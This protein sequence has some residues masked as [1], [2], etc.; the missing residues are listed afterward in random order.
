MNIT[1]IT[2]LALLIPTMLLARGEPFRTDINP[3]LLYYRAFELAPQSM[4]ESNLDYLYSKEGSSEK[5]PERFG[6]ILALY[7]NAFEMVRQAAQQTVPCDWGVDLSAGPATL[8]PHLALAKRVAIAARW[9]V[10]WDLQNGREAAARDDLLGAMALARN[11][12]DSTNDTLI[13]LL[14]EFAMAKIIDTSVAENFGRFSPETL[15]S[16]SD[17]FDALP[18]RTTVANE[19]MGETDLHG[20]WL[21]SRIQELREQHPG[22]DAAVMEGLRK[23]FSAFTEWNWEDFANAAGGTSEGV[24]KMA[25]SDVPLHEQLKAILTLPSGAYEKQAEQF[26]A[27]A[28]KSGNFFFTQSFPPW[29]R[30]RVK[31]LSTQAIQAMLRAAVEYKLHGQTGFQS[32]MDPLG[33][34]PFAFQRFVLQ[35]EDRGFE[36]Q[37][38]YTGQAYPCALIFVEKPGV[39][40]ATSGTN[41]G[42]LIPQPR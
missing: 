6:P 29:L 34:G 13:A 14:V 40:F 26:E 42:N 20:K 25:A 22:D 32:V 18:P 4:A 31:E 41:M 28:H 10:M 38:A 35:G 21:T 37:S 33:N 8:L 24:L 7:D 2:C 12:A 11:L 5:I 36:L 30:S 23:L 1:K 39:S 17:G 19:V 16:L 15:K 3:A 9:R 27:E